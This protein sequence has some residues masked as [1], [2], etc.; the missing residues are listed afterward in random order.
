MELHFEDLAL[1]IKATDLDVPYNM[2]DETLFLTVRSDLTDLLSNKK[3]EIFYFGLA[4]DNTA[5]GQD[6]LLENGIFYRIIGYEKN[7]GIDLESSPEEILSAFH[8]LV[9]NFQP[10]WATIFV[11]E[12]VSKKEV[13]IELMYQEILLNDKK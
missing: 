1:T 11:E 5:D 10:R 2:R 9:S 7:L 8:Y 4:P 12:G 6:E 3:T 13:T